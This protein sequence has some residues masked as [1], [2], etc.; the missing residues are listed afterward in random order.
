M[1]CLQTGKNCGAIATAAR[2]ALLVD[3]ANYF[4]AVEWGLSHARR[5]ILIIGWDFD[6]NIRL[7]GE[8]GEALGPMLRRLLEQQP[9][10]E[11]RILLWS[12][13][14]IH[15]PGD[16]K[17]KLLG[18]PWQE[19]PRLHLKLDR[20]HPFYACHHQKIVAVDDSI[21]F[22]GGIDLTVGRRDTPGHR[23]RSH[24]RRDPDGQPYGPVHDLQMMVDGPAAHMVA[25]VARTRWLNATGERLAP[26]I[27]RSLW[28]ES[29]V[30]EFQDVP[31]A[32]S[33]TAPPWRRRAAV[34]EGAALT[35]DLLRQARR[36]LYVE[37]Q[38]F[39]ADFIADILA[40]GLEQPDG[41]EIVLVISAEWHSQV[42][43]LV[44]G[45]NRNRL[46]RRLKRADRYGRL[47]A[48]YPVVPCDP[49]A[50]ED[51]C[52][53][54]VHAKVIIA[55]DRLMRIGS[56]NLNNRSTGLDTECDLVVEADEPAHRAAILNLRHRLLAEHMGTEAA[57]VSQL[58]AETGSVI[59]TIRR[60]HHGRRR[61][62]PISVSAEGPVTPV[63]GT[64]L[65][66]P[67]EPFGW[68]RRRASHRGGERSLRPP[69]TQPGPAPAE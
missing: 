38:Y 32:V 45:R 29:I 41:P 1:T 65:I 33:C 49:P 40:P 46:L 28:P 12:L 6:G 11:V 14:F 3:A 17:A 20:E 16:P 50:E 30:P 19:H 10:L 36:T 43:R 27:Q 5:S 9:Q 18:A 4:S 60:L 39:T 44:L 47:A 31:I 8:K 37:A 15:A 52:R 2:A 64:G 35:A 68:R 67:A 69:R 53:V 42:E 63:F 21:A 23:A 34:G 57:A 62:E 48:F 25:E 24:R 22:V 13:S 54:L 26:A 61:L 58:V 66:D 55:D 56:S 51:I 7:G 59:E